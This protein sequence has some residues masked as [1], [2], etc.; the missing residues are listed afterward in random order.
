MT[1][2]RV[3]ACPECSSRSVETERL[4]SNTHSLNVKATV[5]CGKCGKCGHEWEDQVSNP[6]KRSPWLLDR[7]RG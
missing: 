6:D 5:T 2:I 3:I 4:E 1:S 7:G